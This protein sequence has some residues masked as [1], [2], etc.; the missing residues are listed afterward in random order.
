MSQ[1]RT[2]DRRSVTGARMW[3]KR[4]V[5]QVL[6]CL[7][8]FVTCNH[9]R[10]GSLNI[11]QCYTVVLVL[12]IYVCMC[13]RLWLCV[14]HMEQLNICIC[15]RVFVNYCICV[16]VNL[17]SYLCIF[18]CL[19]DCGCVCVWHTG[20]CSGDSISVIVFVF[21]SV[22]LCICECLLDC[23]YVCVTYR[24]LQRRCER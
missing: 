1:V 4:C 22:N 15:I 21:V 23:G 9:L 16:I 17:Y 8:S 24:V 12:F 19:L 6:R 11:L 2:C 10:H 18:V 7:T 14:W 3:Q 5:S 13:F 20:C